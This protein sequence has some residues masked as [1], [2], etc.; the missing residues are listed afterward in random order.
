MELAVTTAAIVWLAPSMALLAIAGAAATAAIPLLGHSVMAERDLRHRTHAG[1]LARFHLDALLGRTAI[2]AHNAA[3]MLE[4]EHEQLLG[5]WRSA[6]VALQR[7]TV[8]IEGL[9]MLV[10]FGVAAWLIASH[11]HQ[12]ADMSG[13]L[14]LVYWV[15]NV[16]ALGYEL[17]LTLREYPAH[18]TTILRLLE[19]LEG[20]EDPACK[21]GP[22][23]ATARDNI[24]R[25]DSVERSDR[26]DRA[27]AHL[28]VDL[29]FRAAAVVVSDQA[30]LQDVNLHVP[31]GSHIAVVGP[32]G[33]GKSTLASVLLGWH[34][35]AEGEVLVDGRPLVG[36]EIA[37]LRRRTA[38][39]DPTVQIWNRS[40][41]DNLLY[42]VDAADRERSSDESIAATLEAA[43]L[44]T[45][46]TRLENGL[47]TE[48]G[49]G[50]T[51]LSAGEAQRVRLGRALQHTAPSL[52]LLDEPFRGLERERRRTLVARVRERWPHSTVLYVTHDIAEAF[53]FERVVVVDRGRIVEDG[54]PLLLSQ[55]PSSRYRRMLHAHEALH[56]RFTAGVEWRRITFADGR[57][58]HQGADVPIEQTA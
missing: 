33:A 45:V 26:G 37:N 16:P 39:I 24:D 14:L 19:L 11:F 21:E 54:D 51:L 53:A 12:R 47:A 38:W 36:H 46:V 40:L 1:A 9:Q 32:S 44:L 17:A 57:I 13:M 5:E 49:E 35:L 28:G 42:G 2:D 4:R 34:P 29:D 27:G 23:T 10:G 25:V 55:R 15:L 20:A 50:G 48:L 52:V 41:L 3:V 22:R 30:L 31:S 58:V 6:G 7:S 8:A 18:R 43:E 56:A